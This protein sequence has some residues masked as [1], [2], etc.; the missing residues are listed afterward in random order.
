MHIDVIR[1][2]LAT[3]VRTAAQHVLGDIQP[4]PNPYGAP[5]PI[6]AVIAGDTGTP[7]DLLQS[8]PFRHLTPAEFMAISESGRGEIE[9]LA[10]G[11]FMEATRPGKTGAR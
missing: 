3:Q 4:A 5:T 8:W 10:R 11:M 7:A 1:H 9:A 2:R 6:R